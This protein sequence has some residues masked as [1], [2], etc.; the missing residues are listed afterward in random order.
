VVTLRPPYVFGP[1]NPFYREAFFWDRMRD[2][3]PIIVPGD[4]RRLMQFV[5]VKD[6]VDACLAAMEEVKAVG[7]P[8]NVSNP[9]P[10]NQNQLIKSLAA[11]GGFKA[12][13][14][15]VPRPRIARA[16]GHPI[17]PPLYFAVYFD[18]APITMV[19]QKARRVL[20]FKATPFPEALEETYRWYRR[21]H[22]KGKIDYSFEDGLI[23][24]VLKA[25]RRR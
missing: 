17:H 3:R 21:H 10:V 19:T 16:G 5:Y 25:K 24:P 12:R 13:T 1:E 18:M 14:V 20:S 4:G 8:F 6:L 7:H 15:H 23:E 2:D 9:R 11:A 22:K